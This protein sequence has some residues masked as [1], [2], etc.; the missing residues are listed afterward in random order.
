MN[1]E[2][3]RQLHP[4]LVDALGDPVVA[5]WTPPSCDQRWYVIPDATDWDNVLSWL[6]QRALPEYVPG[7]LRRARSPHFVDPDLQTTDELAARRS[8]DEL[9]ARYAEEKLGL[10][11]DLREAETHA[12]PVRYGLLYG[13]GAEL[14]R[15]VAAVLAAAGLSTVDLDEELGAT[16]S[17]DLLVTA[18]GS[19][20][21]LVEVKAVSGA[22]QEHL[23]G[24][25]QRH[26]DTWPQLRPDQPVTGGVLVVN[27]QHKLHPSER[28]ARVYSRPEFV[29]ALPVTVLSTV[30][31][32][33]WWRTSD[34]AAIRAAVGGADTLAP[35]VAPTE[36][37]LPIDA[38]EPAALRPS[39]KR[40]WWWPEARTP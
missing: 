26:L 9:E 29:A 15:V 3:E 31:L 18:G 22:A 5:T 1:H 32:F 13:T 10:E 7:A 30:E 40:R 35:G 11:E 8:L 6:V 24:H 17:A 16:K 28:A 12:E 14:V 21:R 39:A 23:V 38:T 37:A 34:W 19:P 2:A 36:P 20:Q 4:I 25:L 33:H 27:H